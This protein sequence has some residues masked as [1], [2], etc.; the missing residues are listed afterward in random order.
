MSKITIDQKSVKTLFSEKKADFL[1]PDYQRP[2]AW[3]EK[4][5]QTLWDDLFLFAFPENNCDL[6]NGDDEYF[7]GPIVTFKNDEGKLEIIDGQQRLTTLM[8]L[9]RA[10]YAKYGSMKDDKAIK[11]S[12][13]I[14]QCIWK[15]DEFG[16]PDKT[17]LKINSEVATDKQKDEFLNILKTGV[18]PDNASSSYANNYRFFQQ[19]IVSFQSEYSDWF[20]KLPV[21]IMN[22]CILLPIE[23]ESQDT[24]LRIFSTLN[25][26]GKPLSDADIFKAQFYKFYSSKGQK[27][28]FIQ[29]WKD[30]EVL[31]DSIFHPIT[32]T[33]M[34]EIF[35]RYMY[36]ERAKQGIKSSTT[37]AL[38][39][40][41]EKNTYSLLKKD[42]T[43]DNIID[44]ANFWN[45]VQNQSVERFSDRVLR[46][47]FVLNYAPNGMWT[48]FVSVYYMANRNAAGSLDD[49]KFFDF[50][51]KITAFIWAY[52][53]TNPGVNA[54]RTPVFAEMINIV[55][56]QPVTFEGYLFHTQQ[57]QNAL[58]N[59]VFSN[60]RAIT[61]SML[62]WWEFQNPGQELLSLENALE[63][64]H[65]FARKRQELE[66]SLSNPRNIES[67][68]NK[69][70]LEKR[71]NIRAADYHFADKAKYYLGGENSRKQKREGT[72]IKELLDLAAQISDFTEADIVQRNAKIIFGFIDFMHGNGLLSEE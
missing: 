15:T 56:G 67:L 59:Y 21:R 34:D 62:T 71:I 13:M 17:A 52:A 49:E 4:E 48:Y 42:E 28:E 72:K 35:T 69:A 25:D 39:K 45:D 53:V 14:E 18:I 9:L 29:R 46:R 44:L 57:V 47:L 63:I 38:R 60:N 70:L 2:Y 22:N 36:Y 64:E 11:T 26:R 30:L 31:C 58:N 12:K 61:K 54:L 6:F 10:F 5:C 1:I 68:G 50:L 7:L 66:Q 19:K 51:N 40:F 37:E 8:L 33:P 20:S 16:D 24:A 3:G 41:Y 23:A 55:N 27:E 32:G 65:I 43:F